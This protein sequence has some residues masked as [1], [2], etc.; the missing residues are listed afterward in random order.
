MLRIHSV[1]A[2]P[3]IWMNIYT[4]TLGVWEAKC[5]RRVL[6]WCLSLEICKRW[7]SFFP[8]FPVAQ[9]RRRWSDWA[10]LIFHSN[11]NAIG[12]TRN[13]VRV[14]F[15]FCRCCGASVRILNDANYAEEY[16]GISFM[17]NKTIKMARESHKIIYDLYAVR[18]VTVLF[19]I[20]RHTRSF[21]HSR[22]T[23]SSS[24]MKWFASIFFLPS[25]TYF[26]NA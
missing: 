7:K 25:L 1:V 26:R 12:Q 13:M 6:I 16:N 8:V 4:N 5:Q 2:T 17:W 10:R 21:S 22:F 15:F 23:I 3:I 19:F 18:I 20:R 14:Y 11:Y 9:R 24:H